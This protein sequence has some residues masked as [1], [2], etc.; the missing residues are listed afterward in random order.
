MWGI[1]T[2]PC[3]ILYNLLSYNS[4]GWRAFWDSNFTATSWKIQI[5]KVKLF[6]EQP[7]VHTHPY[8]CRSPHL[9]YQ[10]ATYAGIP[11]VM[12]I[13]PRHWWHH[14]WT[15]SGRSE[16]GGSC[17]NFNKSLVYGL[18]QTY[19]L[20]MPPKPSG[21]VRFL[22]SIASSTNALFFFKAWGRFIRTGASYVY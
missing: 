2:P 19:C 22:R 17:G 15:A 14:Q 10:W 9:T 16:V 11:H 13:L 6:V 18:P 1:P 7:R 20:Q 12:H 8:K 5:K 4:W 21:S 3:K